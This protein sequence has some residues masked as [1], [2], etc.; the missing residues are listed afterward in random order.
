MWGGLTID[1]GELTVDVGE[2]SVELR[3]QL[4]MGSDN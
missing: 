3:D 4:L 1:V 2:T